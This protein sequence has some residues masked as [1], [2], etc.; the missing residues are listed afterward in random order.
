MYRHEAQTTTT[1]L[2][3]LHSAKKINQGA[4]HNGKLGDELAYFWVQS[5]H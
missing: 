5:T 1:K 3:I 2:R 4:V